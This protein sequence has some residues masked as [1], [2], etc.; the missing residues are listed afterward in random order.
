MV[1]FKKAVALLLAAAAA[2]SLNAASMSSKSVYNK[3]CASCHGKHGEGNKNIPD[4]P[5]LNKLT[6]EELVS[7]LSEIKGE[8]FGKYHEKMADNQK[9][10]E[11]RGM[12]YSSEEMAEYIANKLSK[13]K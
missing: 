13:K 10:I 6:K 3:V 1:S 4:A 5:A 9:I 11:L 7:K 12:K 2:C 8:G